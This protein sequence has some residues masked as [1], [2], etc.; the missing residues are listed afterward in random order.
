MVAAK[1]DDF[2][3]SG[4]A[5]AKENDTGGMTYY[6][7]HAAR[8]LGPQQF[9]Y[10]LSVPTSAVYLNEKTKTTS[11]VAY[12]PGDEPAKADVYKGDQRVGSITIPH[13][14]WCGRRRC[15]RKTERK[16][17]TEAQRGGWRHGA[18]C[19]CSLSRYVRE[20]AGVRASLRN[21]KVMRYAVRPSP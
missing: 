13:V 6:W 8:F 20:R 14:R 9:E 12:N 3:A 11:Y 1:F 19:L 4:N 18:F 21:N 15:S 5:I 10:H 17:D 2:A 7:T 16:Y